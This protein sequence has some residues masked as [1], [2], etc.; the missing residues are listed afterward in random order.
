MI[1]GAISALCTLPLA[2]PLDVSGHDLALLLVLGVFQL[3][4]PC[5]LVMHAARYLTAAETSLL[6]LLE[7]VFG[8]LLTWAFGGEQPGA[9]TLLGGCAVLAALVFNELSAADRDDPG[10]ASVS[11]PPA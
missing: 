8:I 3:G 10:R 5:V 1:G 9:A 6:A 7:V 2:W 11:A 4:I